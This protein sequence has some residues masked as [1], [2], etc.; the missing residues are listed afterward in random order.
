MAKCND[1]EK[2]EKCEDCGKRIFP[3]KSNIKFFCSCSCH[4]P[5]GI[6]TGYPYC[7]PCRGNTTTPG[8]GGWTYGEK[9]VVDDIPCVHKNCSGC[10]AGTCNGVHMISC[11]CRSCTPRM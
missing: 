10:K 1:C 3:D 8:W 6:G 11:P 2:F 4:S 7:C 9:P 5:G